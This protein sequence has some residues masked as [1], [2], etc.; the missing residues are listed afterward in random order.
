MGFLLGG[1]LWPIVRSGNVAMRMG[2]LLLVFGCAFLGARLARLLNVKLGLVTREE[3]VRQFLDSP[4]AI[5][6]YKNYVYVVMCYL[7]LLDRGAEKSGFDFHVARLLA[8]EVD[9]VSLLDGFIFS[10][11]YIA[12]LDRLGCQYYF[13]R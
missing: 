1:T 7:G 5:A 10:P 4:E 8:N 12:R 11:E 13:F 9:V 2:Y 3:L 6:K